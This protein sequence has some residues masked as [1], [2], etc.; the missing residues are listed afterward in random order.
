MD[1]LQTRTPAG[2]PGALM[3]PREDSEEFLARLWK[4]VEKAPPRPAA[5]KEPPRS[6]PPQ[7]GLEIV[8]FA[9]D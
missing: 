7:K 3:A 5:P 4:A 1:S 6:S 2:P 8:R 9:L